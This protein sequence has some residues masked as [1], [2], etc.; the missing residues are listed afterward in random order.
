MLD[1]GTGGGDDGTG[2]GTHTTTL[3]LTGSNNAVEGG[4][5]TYT[6]TLGKAATADVTV[7]LSYGGTATAGSDYS[8]T[9]TVTIPSGSSSA[10][11]SV[12]ALADGVTE[13][14]ETLIVTIATA[15]GGGFDAIVSDASQHSVTTTLTD[16]AVLQLDLDADNS[17]ATGTGFSAHYVA[18]GSAVSIADTDLRIETAS[19]STTLS[20]ASIVLTNAK[21]GDLLTVGALPSSITATLQGG[22]VTLSGTASIADYQAALQTISFSN[23]GS[24]PDTSNR[25][26]AVTVSDVSGTSAVANATVVV[27]LVDAAPKAG[28]DTATVSESA[29]LSVNAADGVIKSGSVSSGQ[30]T[31]ADADKLSITGIRT[32]LETATTGTTGSVGQALAGT[33]GSLTLNSDGSYT[34]TPTN[35]GSL[36]AGAK[37]TDVF[38]YTVSDGKGGSDKATLTVTVVGVNDPPV[39]HDDTGFVLQGK[40][41]TVSSTN[42]VVTSS[43]VPGGADL[44]PDTVNA[45]S[46]GLT[47]TAVR[48]GSESGSGSAGQVGVKLSGE[49]G[50]LTLSSSGAYTY[51][52][53]NAAALTANQTATDNFAYTISDGKGGFDTATLS[54]TISGVNDKPSAGNDTAS[55]NEKDTLTVLA[56]NGV[57]QSGQ[58]TGGVDS[59]PDGS[60]TV[61]A[62]RTGSET[63]SGTP[64]TIGQV[65]TGSYGDLTLQSDGSYTYVANHADSLAQDVVKADVFTYTVSDGQSGTDTATLTI[66]V[67]G[68]NDAPTAH[69]DT[70]SVAENGLLTVSSTNGV[71]SSSSH[72]QGADT[73]PDTSS[74]TVSTFGAGS[75]GTAHAAGETVTGTYGQLTLSSGGGY[76]YNANR[77]D[78]LVA[79]EPA[80]DV[81]TY[82]VSDGKGGFSTATLT[83][84]V[85]GINDAPSATNDTNTVQENGMLN[86]SN[87]L[88]ND[89]DADADGSLTVTAIQANSSSGTTTSGALD[90]VLH[91]SYGDLTMHSDGSYAYDANNAESLSAT[92]NKID[93]F[94]YTVS[95]DQSSTKTATLK[96]TVTGVND[97]PVASNDTGSVSQDGTLTVINSSGVITGDLTSAG[98][99]TDVDSSSLKVFSFHA[100]EASNSSATLYS[101]GGTATGTYG[102][103]TLASGGGY[104]YKANNAH[105]LIADQKATDVFTYTVTDGDKTDTA[106]L[107]ITI[108]GTDDPLTTGNDTNSI[109]ENATPL[110][111]SAANGVILSGLSSAGVDYDLDSSSVTVTTFRAGSGTSLGTAVSAGTTLLGTYGH[112]TLNADGSYKYTADNADALAYG[113]KATDVFT[114]TVE[115]AEKNPATATLT[116]TVTGVNDAPVAVDDSNS[117]AEQISS[118]S[119]T[120]NKATGNVITDASGKD[121]D[122][123]KDTLTISS[124]HAGDASSTNATVSAG[125]TVT[126]DYG[127][128]QLLSTG[129]YTYTPGTSSNTLAAGAT[130]DDKFTYTVSDGKGGTAT[131]TLTITI[132]GSNDAAVITGDTTK[133]ITEDNLVADAVVASGTLVST[134]VDNDATFEATD[135]DGLYG[136]FSL[137][138]DGN[139][140]YKANGTHDAFA[141][142]ITY[143]DSF[144]VYSIDK[145]STTV[146]V[147]IAGINDAPT[148]VG[149]INSVTEGSEIAKGTAGANVITGTGKDSDAEGDTF[150]VTGA[151][152]G[153]ETS[154]MTEITSTTSYQVIQGS[155]GTLH[156]RGDGQYYYTDVQGPDSLAKD[157]T[158]EDVFTYEITDSNNATAT[159][160]LKITVKGDDNETI[161]GTMGYGTLT[162]DFGLNGEYYKLNKGTTDDL[163]SWVNMKGADVAGTAASAATGVPDWRFTATEIDYHLAGTGSSTMSSSGLA[164]FLNYG[165]AD[166]GNSV[167]SEAGGQSNSYA[168]LRLTG[169]VYFGPGWGDY[170]IRVT[171]DDAFRL[172]LGD[173]VVLEKNSAGT[174]TIS[175]VTLAGGLVDFE[176]LMVDRGADST[177]KIEVKASGAADSA[178]KVLGESNDLFTQE[179]APTLSSFQT[180]L[181]D[182]RVHRHDTERRGWQ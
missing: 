113:I 88:S 100:G 165:D 12:S 15:T 182:K 13:P 155:Y 11:F 31:D 126:T 178:Y 122:V 87:V 29:T 34:Y 85:T 68:V 145:T 67:K 103:L 131:A 89:S 35:G 137:A 177:L 136:K 150:T 134:D 7:T 62:V 114:Y 175:S 65:L 25:V 141:K 98:K 140:T 109:D 17:S 124:F 119:S 45:T 149:D 138:S 86:A 10:S 125:G 66:N 27:T 48:T 2:G 110:D 127:Q 64:G 9:A 78:A 176:A 37:V 163:D 70:G 82:T 69:A 55:V 4:T 101:A 32:G 58:S 102:Q 73:D 128:L 168:G 123:D 23:S 118:T 83:I 24:A 52:A 133:N 156:L 81:F 161:T 38:T 115:N 147:N 54:I 139:W 144:T 159:A 142:D 74:L 164:T 63:G 49:Y 21:S 120:I 179:D 57:I 162:N 14:A 152:A 80:T 44:D 157:A 105:G 174:Y 39:A 121:S 148:A 26:I 99:D 167:R 51:T 20:G 42:G 71:I 40:S 169:E 60:L 95:D 30:D 143:T 173:E 112:L 181:V 47:V 46:S 106:T 1:S 129:K 154:S 72:P 18:R 5:A 6:L 84:T 158:V 59:D 96:I 170:D 56:A 33:Y 107:T 108:T 76:T 130:F 93:T 117:V 180:I 79:N 94:T 28:N 132:N 104:T 91:G 53:N 146:T 92:D 153:T 8:G 166:D 111:V 19:G 16:N 3:S 97:A 50:D 172:S 61:T 36:A 116:I 75:D 90:Q 41:L 43:S 77:A 151:T 135:A 171:C 22:N 160:T